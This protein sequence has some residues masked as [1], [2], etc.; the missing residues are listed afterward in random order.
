MLIAL[1]LIL[2]AGFIKIHPL[3]I[4]FEIEEVALLD[5]DK[6][7]AS[8]AAGRLF[9]QALIQKLRH[10]EYIKSFNHLFNHEGRERYL[11]NAAI[12]QCE[13]SQSEFKKFTQWKKKNKNIDIFLPGQPYD[14]KF[15]SNT[16]KHLIS[17]RL[18]A[19]ANGVSY[20]DAYAYC[21]AAGGRLPYSDEWVAVAAGAGQRLYPWGNEFNKT[22]WPYINPL[23]NASQRCGLHEQTDTEEGISDLG[24]NVSEWAQDRDNPIVATIHG[25]NAYN[26][27]YKL[28]SLNHLYRYAPPDYRSPYVGFRCIYDG[29]APGRLPWNVQTKTV[30]LKARKYRTG[31]PQGANIPGLIA[32]LPVEQIDQIQRILRRKEKSDAAP[33]MLM[34]HE[35][36]RAQYAFFLA[37]PLVKLG[38]YADTEEPLN[39]SYLPNNW[40]QQ[41]QNP[42]LP[43]TQVDWWSAYA[44]ANWAGGR[45]PTTEEW[46]LA[47]SSNGRSVYPW[48]QDFVAGYAATAESQLKQTASPGSFAEDKTQEGI[49]DMGGN[50][51]EWTSSMDVAHGGYTMIVKG[52]NY[53]LPGR[54]SARIDFENKVPANYRSPSI[55][56][57]VAF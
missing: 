29:E 13:V 43:V 19:P 50:I 33:I 1:L 37:D 36:S 24:H 30:N 26:K 9:D 6:R 25:G 15:H 34:K 20:Y 32:R 51:S 21:R 39:H 5:G 3:L 53:M 47:A 40:N 4:D 49:F 48:G 16:E 54:K 12:D 28:Y 31:I 10:F 27:P 44:F 56:F 23:L 18:E 41:M 46:A 22:G 45:L 17:G 57:R 55:G 7:L 52:G 11:E 8:R 42:E 14:W 38:L 35:V 2:L